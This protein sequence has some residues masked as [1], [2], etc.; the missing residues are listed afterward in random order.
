MENSF[1]PN[2]YCVVCEYYGNKIKCPL[3]KALD[4]AA[5]NV[6]KQMPDMDLRFHVI[7]DKF[8]FKEVAPCR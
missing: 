2:A 6:G 5:R 8:E 4:E 7:C 3:Y 1:N